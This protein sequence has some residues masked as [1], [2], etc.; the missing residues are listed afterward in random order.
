MSSETLPKQQ[1]NTRAEI[2]PDEA[3]LIWDEYKYRHDLVWRHLIRSTVAVIALITVSYSTEFKDDIVLFIISALLAVI[4]TVFSF[5]VLNSELALYEKIKVLHRQRQNHLYKLH[6]GEKPL[7]RELVGTFS[8][9]A[10]FYLA[11]LLFLALA[12]AV[13]HIW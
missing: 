12:A 9:R 3:N 13:S 5:I 6:T 8:S 2:G 1:V 7:P 4:Y 10:R 11:G